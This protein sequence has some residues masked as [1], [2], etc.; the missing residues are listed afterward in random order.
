MNFTLV[1]A[2]FT[3]TRPKALAS[4]DHF[5]HLSIRLRLA[6]ENLIVIPRI[7]DLHRSMSGNGRYSDG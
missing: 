7:Q 6:R 5:L 3:Q 4:P 1:A 2:M